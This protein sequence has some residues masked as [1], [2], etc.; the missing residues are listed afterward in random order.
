MRVP[1]DVRQ[2]LPHERRDVVGE[3]GLRD[4]V[5]RTGERHGG[6][7][8]EGGADLADDVE[9][10]VPQTVLVVAGAR[11][12]EDDGP[13][14]GDRVVQDLHRR[15]QLRGHRARSDGRFDALQLHPGTEQLLD[16]VVVQVPCDA[17]A[18]LEQQH[19]LPV[20]PRRGQLD[21]ERRLA[22]ERRRA[23]QV[24][25]RERHRAR[26]T[27]SEQHRS[28]GVP[29]LERYEKCR[30]EERGGERERRREVFGTRCLGSLEDGAEL[31][32]GKRKVRRQVGRDLSGSHHPP[33]KPVLCIRL[34]NAR[35]VRSRQPLP[36]APSAPRRASP[37]SVPCRA[38][39]ISAVAALHA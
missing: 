7:F 13:D 17:R 39:V 12:R 22:G 16:D 35:E 32:V 30:P 23:L 4:D 14:A 38:A 15:I 27:G 2:P 34:E 11:E 10:T 28:A 31:P 3:R 8:R 18:V 26:P 19:P 20:G 24:E 36:H 37:V 21:R 1:D 5:D 25:R 29:A 6:R 9:Q 33:H